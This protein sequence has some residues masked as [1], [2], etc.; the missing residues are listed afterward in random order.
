[1]I[2][3]TNLEVAIW[4][5]IAIANPLPLNQW[6]KIVNCTVTSVP[7]PIPYNT[8]P[9]TITWNETKLADMATKILPVA[10]KDV[11]RM[12]PSDVPNIS[13][14]M[15]PRSDRIVLTNGADDWIIP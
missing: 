10:I 13:I 4:A 6:L 12:D 3:L 7:L 8:L 5:P 14:N 11:A 9:K 15:P 1:M 2:I